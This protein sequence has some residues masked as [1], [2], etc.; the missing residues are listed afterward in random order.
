MP[1]SGSPKAHV[2]DITI[3]NSDPEDLLD[4]HVL[5]FL[6]HHPKEARRHTLERLE[7]GVYQIDG[8]KVDVEWQ[9]AAEA[10]QPGHLVVVDGPLRQPFAD[11]LENNDTNAEYSTHMI[12]RTSALHHVPKE[13]R[14]TFDDTNKKYTRLEAM[15]VAKEQA[16]IRE[17]AADYTKEGRLVPDELVRR[18]NKA[19][20]QKLSQAR[21]RA[22]QD[23]PSLRHGRSEPPAPREPVPATAE[24]SGVQQQQ[25]APAPANVE[26]ESLCAAPTVALMAHRGISLNGLPS[27]MHPQQAA[28]GPFSVGISRSWSGTN[29]P[30]SGGSPTLAPP[31]L[32]MPPGVA[33]PAPLGQVAATSSPMASVHVPAGPLPPHLALAKTPLGYY[34]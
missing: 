6:R 26:A 9:H 4:Q 12:A 27:C 14:M 17:K 10:G 24:P 5:Y 21:A 11:Y 3:A 16:S 30:A 13:A 29:M 2:R 19:L 8:H 28:L 20:R 1:S 23:S 33:M 18:Y 22:A 25:P 32:K 31:R 15:K 7:A 34:R